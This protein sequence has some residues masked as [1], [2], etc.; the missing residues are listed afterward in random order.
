M[1]VHAAL[2]AVLADH[3][4]ET[5]F[6]VLGDGNM[7]VMGSFIAEQ[8]GRYVAAANEAGTVLMAAGHAWGTGSV[9]IA[10]VTHGPGLANTLGTLISACRERVSIVVIAGDTHRDRRGHSQDIEQASVVAPTGAGFERALSAGSAPSDLIRAMRRA[11]GERRPIVFNLPVD[12][13]FG[14]T[15]YVPGVQQVLPQV[16]ATRPDPSAM[17]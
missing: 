5:V 11:K 12:L 16:Q 15:D 14:E 1:K 6:G 8:E 13:T 4:V 17:V 7:F 10:T 2:A 3:G 9:G